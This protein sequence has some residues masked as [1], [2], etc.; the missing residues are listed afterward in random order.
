MS[1]EKHNAKIG[2]RID[3]TKNARKY[4]EKG[5]KKNFEI[6]N[7]TKTNSLIEELV[8]T[9]IKE[10]VLGNDY[11]LSLVIVGKNEMKKL[12]KS[13]GNK[14]QATDILSFPL[15]DKE[16]EIFICPEIAIK[17]APRFGRSR[18]NFIKYLFIHSLAHL[19]GFRHSGKMESEEKKIRD[20]FGV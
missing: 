5:V 19:K 4:M 6:S 1:N 15:S 11:D 18:E 16:G 3:Q 2:V 14:D 10:T 20:K 12:N 13:Y 8:F 9:K 7:K 17:E